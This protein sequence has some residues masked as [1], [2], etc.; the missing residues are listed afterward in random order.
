[1]IDEDAPGFVS[2]GKERMEACKK[3]T[4]WKIIKGPLKESCPVC[5]CD[6]DKDIVQ[7]NSC[8][9]HIFHKDCIVHCY[10]VQGFL[11]CPICN[12]IYGTRIGSMP[13]G[14]MNVEKKAKGELVLEGYNNCGTIV[15]NYNFPSGTQVEGQ[16]SPGEYYNG[17]SRTAYLPDNPEGNEV[18]KLLELAWKRKVTFIIGTSVTTGE[19]NTVVWNGIHHKTCQ[20]GGPTAYG[21]PDETYFVR[22]KAELKDLGVE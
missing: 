6:L 15:I 12:Y 9:G 2:P 11:K 19:R 21:Y 3:L 17:T 20:S 16:P 8:V 22:V 14:T 5:L 4:K 18:L 1:L 13:D 7:L 10:N